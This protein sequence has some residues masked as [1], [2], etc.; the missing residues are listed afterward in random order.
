MTKS[1][2]T[3]EVATPAKL[4][5]ISTTPKKLDE[6]SDREL[7]KVSGGMRK[8]GGDPSS[9]GKPFLRFKFDT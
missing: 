4:D 6:I 7:D 5:D 2:K 3:R 8:S 1:K 9:A